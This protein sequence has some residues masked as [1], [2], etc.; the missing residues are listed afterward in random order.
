MSHIVYAMLLDNIP[1]RPCEVKD[2]QDWGSERDYNYY[3]L[4]RLWK[5]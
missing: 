1:F 3:L 2:F 4:D 5:Y